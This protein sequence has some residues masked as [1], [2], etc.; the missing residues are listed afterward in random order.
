MFNFILMRYFA[1]GILQ[2]MTHFF[3]PLKQLVVNVQKSETG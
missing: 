3:L 2:A 1:A